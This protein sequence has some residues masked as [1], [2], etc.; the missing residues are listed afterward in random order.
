MRFKRFGLTVCV[1]LFAIPASGKQA[2]QNT[3]TPQPA[4]DP[5]AV[6]VVQAAI[7]ALGGATTIVKSDTWEIQGQFDGPSGTSSQD[8]TINRQV[9]NATIVV[10]GVSKPAP[11]FVTPSV[12]LPVLVGAILLQESQ[13]SNFALRFDPPSSLAS[14][15]VNVIKFLDSTTQVIAQVWVF[16]TVTNLP[17]RVYFNSVAEIGQAK[18]YR[19]TVDLSNYRIVSGVM[20]PFSIGVYI[21]NQLP[22]SLTVLSLTA[23][24]IATGGVQ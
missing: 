10:K 17:V 12:F 7:T 21:K 5:Q 8:E 22:E 24:Q 2:I 14:T 1:L 19:A 23:S 11:K 6:A 16:D 9:P 20:Y 13:D 3:T 18:T 4:N 15:P